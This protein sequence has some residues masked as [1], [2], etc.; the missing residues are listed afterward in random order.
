MRLSNVH[1]FSE[2]PKSDFKQCID[3]LADN[4]Q[5][6]SKAANK[7]LHEIVLINIHK[8]KQK[9]QWVACNNNTIFDM[10][11]QDL[12]SLVPMVLTVPTVEKQ[13]LMEQP[14]KAQWDKAQSLHKFPWPNHK[15]SNARPYLLH[16]EYRNPSPEETP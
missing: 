1:D 6:C 8:D 2:V 14:Y 15:V 3:I 7:Q 16:K 11:C 5:L 10:P 9:A 12:P 13:L 4:V